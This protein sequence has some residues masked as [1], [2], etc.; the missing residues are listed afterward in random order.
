ME[1]RRLLTEYKTDT[2]VESFCN[3]GRTCGESIMLAWAASTGVMYNHSAL[4]CYFD[5]N[6]PHPIKTLLFF[7][8][9]CKMEKT[10]RSMGNLVPGYL[11]FPII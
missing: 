2:V 11:F 10:K 9:C 4:A 3:L 8:R 6:T 5:G 7:A 1:L